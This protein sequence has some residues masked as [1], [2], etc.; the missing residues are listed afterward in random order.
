MTDWVLVVNHNQNP[1]YYEIRIAGQLINSGNIPPGGTE[2]PTF[3]SIWGG[4]V[5]V[6]A[7][8]NS[9]KVT[10]SNVVSSQRI[11]YG[12]SFEEVPGMPAA[13]LADNYLWPWYDNQSAGATNWV[14][15]MN[16]NAFAVYYEISVAEQLQSSG[17]I[18]AGSYVVPSYPGLSG[19]PVEV[20]AWTDS[21]KQ[22][23]ATV[24]SSQRVLWNGYF[25]EL[26]G[27]P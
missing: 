13:S 9:S 4:P 21:T 14:L 12:P 26:M 17:N 10:H 8:T 7:W 16:T 20:R 3:P 25:N 11:T 24:I 23:P 22:T 18:A 2:A 5:Q 19:G 1:V 6:E 27:R 15:V